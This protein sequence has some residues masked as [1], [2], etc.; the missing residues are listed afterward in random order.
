MSTHLPSPARIVLLAASILMFAACGAATPTPTASASGDI[1]AALT[2]F[3]IQLG[4]ASAAAG[5]VTFSVKN[6]GTIVH[7]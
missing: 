1:T 5:P 4:A 3:K 2:E 7:E 6:D